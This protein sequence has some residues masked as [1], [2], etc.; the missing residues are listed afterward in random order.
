MRIYVKTG[1]IFI[2]S[3]HFL[4]SPFEIFGNAAQDVKE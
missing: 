4:E 3:Q 2:L 1:H